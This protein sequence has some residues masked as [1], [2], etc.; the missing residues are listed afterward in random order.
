VLAFAGKA[1]AAA[2][3]LATGVMLY[4][5]MGATPMGWLKR[6]N[7]E[8]LNLIGEQLDEAQ[9]ARAS[10]QGRALSAEEAV[11]LALDSLE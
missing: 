1:E 8:A 11:E 4:E 5:D 9:V 10:E 3:V 2:R 7:D 6:G